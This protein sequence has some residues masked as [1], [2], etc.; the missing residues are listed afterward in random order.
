MSVAEAITG[1]IQLRELHVQMDQA[2]LEAYGWHQG[3]EAGPALD[4]RHDFYEV[5]FL[6]ENDRVRYTIHPDARREILKRLLLLNHQRY[7]E[8]ERQGL[9]SK[10]TGKKKTSGILVDKYQQ[11]SF[12]DTEEPD[13]QNGG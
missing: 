9:H 1:I 3:S 2:V 5:D 13:L 6:P 12:F 7:E 11:D 10:K 4:L 8:E